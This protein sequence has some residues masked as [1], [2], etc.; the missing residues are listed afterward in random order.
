MKKLSG[1]KPKIGF[2][3]T[4]IP[5]ECGIGTF[6]NDIVNNISKL[7]KVSEQEN[8]NTLVVAISDKDNFYSYPAEVKF[9][10]NQ[11]NRKNYINAAHFLNNSDIDIVNIQHEFGIF[12]GYDGNFILDTVENLRKPIVTTFHTVLENPSAGQ[13]T[14]VEQMASNSVYVVVLAKRAI[15]ILKTVYKIPEKKIIFIEHGAPNVSFMD[16]SY[17]KS[18]FNASGR[19]IILT[20]GLIN[21]NKGIEYG[22]KAISNIV[23]KHPNVLYIILGTT[24]PEVRKQFGEE[25]RLSLELLVKKLGI[26]NNVEFFNYF[27][28]KKELIKFLIA[29]DIYLTPYL[30]KEQIVSGTLAYALTCGKA[31]ISTPYWYAEELLADKRGILV[32]FKD[33]NAISDAV[34][35]L[36]EDEKQFSQYRK[37][38]YDY[39][40]EFVWENV[41]EKFENAFIRAIENYSDTMKTARAVKR[42]ILPEINLN[43]FKI[44]TDDTGIFQH[45]TMSIPNR[46]FGYTTDDNARA[47]IVAIKN[48][49][50]SK[51]D[52]TIAYIV[53]YLSFLLHA[54]DEE[55][56]SVKNFMNFQRE[57][58]DTKISEDTTGRMVWALGYC[59]KHAPNNS[60]HIISINL[61]KNLISNVTHFT[62][63]RAWS[64]VIIGSIFY[65]SI[66]P[67]DLE[68]KNISTVL[69]KRI[70]DQL[71]SNKDND[72]LWLEDT[73]CYENARIPQ[74][75][76]SYG[77]FF[78]DKK[79]MS[80]AKNTFKWIMEIQT[81]KENNRLT[82]IGNKGW[83]KRSGERAKF[84]Q[85]PV[86][87]AAIVD[88]AYEGYKYTR[89]KYYEEVIEMGIDWFLGNNDVGEAVYDFNNGG[90]RDGIHSLGI[91]LN[92]GAESTL[93]W[94][95][96]LHRLYEL[97]QL[98]IKSGEKYSVNKS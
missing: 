84:D 1:K 11:Q 22:I 23:K 59:L 80:L 26:E 91:N 71:N 48:W 55:T 8:P 29:S 56:E 46:D 78:N 15:N 87:I 4:Y 82:L 60:I 64:F 18:D 30:S 83:M 92:E 72:W 40:R 88:A 47:L 62:S 81:D 42:T 67:G 95:L 27:V 45:C 98:K 77:G 37:N 51:N 34:I 85:Q 57:W 17:Y 38:A 49:Y 43:H 52:D 24:H 3:S 79:I 96:S 28:T 97:N 33:E 5:R 63:P 14:V 75:L 7:H 41:A 32:P 36:L 9:E 61:F 93:S 25:Y 70:T 35:K 19:K 6:T 89:E 31:L 10:I 74:A 66:Y 50:L 73:L 69:T 94:L 58:V 65:L 76:F 53:K 86:E 13:K 16:S 20:F 68:V 2:I 12:G 54:Y 90:S 21:P 44:M 39:G